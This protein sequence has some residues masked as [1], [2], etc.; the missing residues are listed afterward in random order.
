MAVVAARQQG[1]Q[2]NHT[3]LT[4]GSLLLLLVLAVKGL[5]LNKKKKYER[6]ENMKTAS[7]S[8]LGR[9]SLG[10]T[11]FLLISLFIYLF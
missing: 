1:A 5:L 6:H 8:V 7:H 4:A 11:E 2:V 9:D 10:R 3:N